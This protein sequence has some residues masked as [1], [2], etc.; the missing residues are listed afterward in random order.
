MSPFGC[1]P[2]AREEVERCKCECLLR[3]GRRW[4]RH[5]GCDQGVI[6]QLRELVIKQLSSK[7]P[8]VT[9]SITAPLGFLATSA[10]ASTAARTGDSKFTVSMVGEGRCSKG[11]ESV[12]CEV[13]S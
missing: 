1:L 7:L 4:G 10:V 11:G 2:W 12:V 3:D 5:V 13:V 6:D 8:L 9:S